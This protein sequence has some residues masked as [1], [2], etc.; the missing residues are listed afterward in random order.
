[1][2]LRNLNIISED[3]DYILATVEVITFPWRRF[4][5]IPKVEVKKVARKK[6][7]RFWFFVDTGNWTPGFICENLE[8]DKHANTEKSVRYKKANELWQDKIGGES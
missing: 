2:K 4:F 6:I 5:I 3:G 7:T 8:A 1:M